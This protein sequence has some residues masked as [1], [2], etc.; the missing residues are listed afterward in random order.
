MDDITL[1]AK[2]KLI[3]ITHY[4]EKTPFIPTSAKNMIIDLFHCLLLHTPASV[5]IKTGDNHHSPDIFV[6]YM[7]L[8]YAYNQYQQ[9]AHVD[10]V[11]TGKICRTHKSRHY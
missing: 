4:S 10:C 2:F 5:A 1:F 7:P 8:R 6:I 9:V 3:L 11:L